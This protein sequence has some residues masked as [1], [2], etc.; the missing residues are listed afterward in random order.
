MILFLSIFSILII[1]LSTFSDF[2]TL[3]ITFPPL[4]K[5]F[6]TSKEV[7]KH[8]IGSF[9]SRVHL[10]PFIDHFH[11]LNLKKPKISLDFNL[12]TFLFVDLTLTRHCSRF[13][14]EFEELSINFFKREFVH[15]TIVFLL[16]S[17]TSHKNDNK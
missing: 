11:F 2:Q 10:I 13:K 15:L 6:Q 17:Q 12:L 3:K 16:I 7:W 9:H 1:F 4:I 5:G 8:L 14:S